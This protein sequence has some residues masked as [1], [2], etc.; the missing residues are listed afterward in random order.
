MAHSLPVSTS[1]PPRARG[2][3]PVQNTTSNSYNLVAPPAG[4][5][6][7]TNVV[8]GIVKRIASRAP[9]GRNNKHFSAGT[10][11]NKPSTLQ[12]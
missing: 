7:E 6:I 10:Q 11:K 8:V 5:W 12:K 4:A 2:L 9:A 1:R 3:K